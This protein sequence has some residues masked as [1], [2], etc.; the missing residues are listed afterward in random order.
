MIT[1]N[2][3]HETTTNE[4]KLLSHTDKEKRE[5]KG[6][7]TLKKWEI[8]GFETRERDK[9]VHRASASQSQRDHQKGKRDPKKRET[10]R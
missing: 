3:K 4:K 1:R 8:I 7:N 6:Q 2:T 5:R 9:I 10:N